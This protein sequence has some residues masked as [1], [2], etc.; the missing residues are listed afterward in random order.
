[1]AKASPNPAT[2]TVNY[3]AELLSIKTELNS[4]W[5]I[6]TSAVE[7]IKNAITSMTQCH[8]STSEMETPT[9][10]NMETEVKHPPATTSDLSDLI[11]G[12]KH[13]IATKLDISNLIVDLKLDIALIKSHSLESPQNSKPPSFP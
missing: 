8:P 3:D 13:N 5:A 11:A 7:Q 9:L 6:I 4:L 12:L 1:M 2:T 10:S